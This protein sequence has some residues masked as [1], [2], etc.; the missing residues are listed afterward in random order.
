M[1]GTESSDK[2]MV[3]NFLQKSS[4]STSGII[5]GGDDVD[6][7]RESIHSSNDM[8]DMIELLKS[9]SEEIKHD[10]KRSIYDYLTI[11]MTS[12]ILS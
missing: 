2:R 4:N 9:V 11:L 6:V 7:N 5:G 12:L 10:I 1:T 3:L 8:D